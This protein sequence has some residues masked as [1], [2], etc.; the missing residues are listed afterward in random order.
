MKDEL[1]ALGVQN[2]KM[3]DEALFLY[4]GSK[5]FELKVITVFNPLR[6]AVEKCGQCETSLSHGGREKLTEKHQ[7]VS[8]GISWEPRMDV[9]IVHTCRVTLTFILFESLLI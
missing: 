8:D 4:C 5:E 2:S 6:A 3:Y 7:P 1:R 9:L